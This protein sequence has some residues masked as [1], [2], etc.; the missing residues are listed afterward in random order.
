MAGSGRIDGVTRPRISRSDG[1]TPGSAPMR[2]SI[3]TLVTDHDQYAALLSSLWSGGFDG[4]DCEY[5]FIDNSQS[6][7]A[8]AYSG[9]NALLNEAR[10]ERVI[11]CHQDIRLLVDTR[12]G[13]DARLEELDA[14]D[15]AWALAGNAGG[16]G[17]A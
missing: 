16:M 8:C 6:N 9:L 15:P 11:L 13:L 14:F 17:P 2:Y 12:A 4:A 3:A 5:L 10:G 1:V 7:T